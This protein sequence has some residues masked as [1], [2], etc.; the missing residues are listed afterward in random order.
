MLSELKAIPLFASLQDGELNALASGLV[1]RTLSKH[2][3]VINEGDVTD[4]LYVILS[5]RVKVYLGDASG[6]ELVLDI[7]GPGKYFGEMALD[8]GPRSASVMTLERCRFAVISRSDFEGILVKH[9]KVAL[10]VVQNLIR[11]TRGLNENVKSL[12]TLD[13]YGRVAR[14]LLDLATEKD[15][16]TVILNT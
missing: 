4:S 9:P 7:I 16:K 11:R 2:T 15:G 8:G 13:V 12:A 1:V 3:I 5:G 10:R 6:K 14:L